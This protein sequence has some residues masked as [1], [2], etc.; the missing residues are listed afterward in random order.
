MAPEMLAMASCRRARCSETDV[1]IVPRSSSGG[2]FDGDR[3]ASGPPRPALHP[4]P[5]RS[6]PPSPPVVDPTN[7]TGWL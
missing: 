4:P 5:P 6:P 3:P 7:G 1:R 2:R